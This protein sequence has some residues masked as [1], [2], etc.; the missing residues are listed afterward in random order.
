MTQQIAEEQGVQC[1]EQEKQLGDDTRIEELPVSN[2]EQMDLSVLY[3]GDMRLEILK[4]EFYKELIE[5]MNRQGPIKVLRALLDSRKKLEGQRTREHSRTQSNNNN[6]NNNCILDLTETVELSL[7]GMGAATA[8]QV[9]RKIGLRIGV[10]KPLYRVIAKMQP[11]LGRFQIYPFAEA[12]EKAIAKAGAN[13]QKQWRPRHDKG[14]VVAF[15]PR[16]QDVLLLIRD[17][18]HSADFYQVIASY[19]R[20]KDEQSLFEIFFKCKH[21]FVYVWC[22]FFIF[23]LNVN[24]FKSE[25]LKIPAQEGKED[26]LV[27]VDYSIDPRQFLSLLNNDT[28]TQLNQIAQKS[29]TTHKIAATK[30]VDPNMD[31]PNESVLKSDNENNNDNEDNNRNVVTDNATT[32]DNTTNNENEN[33]NDGDS[34]NDGDDDDNQND[35][36]AQ[37]QSHKWSQQMPMP[38]NANANANANINVDTDINAKEKEGRQS[39]PNNPANDATAPKESLTPRKRRWHKLDNP[40]YVP[41]LRDLLVNEYWLNQF[42]RFIEKCQPSR[43]KYLYFLML[44]EHIYKFRTRPYPKQLPILNCDNIAIKLIKQC[45]HKEQYQYT[46]NVPPKKLRRTEQRGS[47]IH[48]RFVSVIVNKSGQVCLMS[49]EE[50]SAAIIGLDELRGIATAIASDVHDNSNLSKDESTGVSET[51]A[52]TEEGATAFSKPQSA[53]LKCTTNDKSKSSSATVSSKPNPKN[54][55]TAAR[56][57]LMAELEQLNLSFNIF[58]FCR[59]NETNFYS[60][61]DY[62]LLIYYN[63]VR[64]GS[65]YLI[66]FSDKQLIIDIEKFLFTTVTDP[67]DT[68]PKKALQ[69]ILP[70]NIFDKMWLAVF[71]YVH[72][73][74]YESFVIWVNDH[75]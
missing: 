71:R 29:A 1:D 67:K 32:N 31:W 9:R 25:A 35:D 36:I 28:L 15:A 4:P 66:Q 47:V 44:G 34:D 11:D 13:S 60:F 56:Q 16:I 39:L 43:L 59:E 24:N 18:Y 40:N 38:T 65:P 37:R 70:F 17:T 52:S 8:I 10:D 51:D 63:F 12:F 73:M 20:T 53:F 72:Q 30:R 22:I 41:N 27:D 75:F 46:V 3:V 23:V 68:T 2:K 55:K 54:D 26:T 5:I 61:N 64:K 74:C 7:S 14:I 42:Q 50:F 49:D 21:T 6:N 62:C 48:V 69:S 58:E 33:G 19:P 45:K 57:E